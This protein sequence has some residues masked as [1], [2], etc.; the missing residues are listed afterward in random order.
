MPAGFSQRPHYPLIPPTICRPFGLPKFGV[1]FW[2]GFSDP[3]AVH[4]PEAAMDKDG[5]TLLFQHD[6]RRSGQRS[7]IRPDAKTEAA[8]QRPDPEFWQRIPV[9]DRRHIAG[10]LNSRMDIHGR[11]GY[12]LAAHRRM[13]GLRKCSK[14]Y[15]KLI[16]LSDASYL[17]FF[18][19]AGTTRVIP[20]K[21]ISLRSA[22]L[23]AASIVIR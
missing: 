10:A 16:T 8:K 5:Q 11:P 20:D 22:V 15:S 3:A 13:P 21:F 23:T 17:F 18:K 9:P 7:D 2:S 4:V 14:K 19:A 12:R 6:V 1:C